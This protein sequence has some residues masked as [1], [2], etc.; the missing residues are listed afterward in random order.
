MPDDRIEDAV[1]SSRQ[2]LMGGRSLDFALIQ[3]QE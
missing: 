2:H 3:P 1:G